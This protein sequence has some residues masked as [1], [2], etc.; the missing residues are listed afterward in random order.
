MNKPSENR[1]LAKKEEIIFKET[2]HA[3]EFDAE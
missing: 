1:W 3:K 2:S